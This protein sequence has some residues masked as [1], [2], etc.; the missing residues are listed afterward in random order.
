V[1]AAAP[2]AS[3]ADPLDRDV[4]VHA[5]VAVRERPGERHRRR[6]VLNRYVYESRDDAGAP[7][8]PAEEKGI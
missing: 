3:T 7:Q 4:A 6:P 5:A 8:A 1:H 2:S